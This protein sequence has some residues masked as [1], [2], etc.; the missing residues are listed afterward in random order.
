ALTSALNPYW[1]VETLRDVVAHSECTAFVYDARSR[2]RG[3][4]GLGLAIARDVA[5]AHGGTLH[6]EDVPEGT[7]FVLRLPMM[8]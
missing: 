8:D 2:D 5:I 1:P 7:R 3:G 4:T 6:V